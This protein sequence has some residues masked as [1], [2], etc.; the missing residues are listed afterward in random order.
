MLGLWLCGCVVGILVQIN[1][2]RVP[3]GL[4]FPHYATTH[5]DLNPRHVLVLA[6]GSFYTVDVLSA[7]GKPY[8]AGQIQ[9]SLQAIVDGKPGAG[10]GGYAEDIGNLT[11]EDRDIWANARAGLLK[12]TNNTALL[13]AVDTGS[14]RVVLVW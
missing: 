4:P 8:S 5:I 3:A 6:N 12:S 10:K 7:D 13:N 11:A 9:A 1:Y 14:L 2:H